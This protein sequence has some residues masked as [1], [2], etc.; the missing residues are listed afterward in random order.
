M[1][2]WNSVINIFGKYT[3]A[4]FTL[5]RISSCFV[6]KVTP[7][8]FEQWYLHRCIAL[9]NLLRFET[10]HTTPVGSGSGVDLVVVASNLPIT[11][12]AIS[13]PTEVYKLGPDH[14]KNLSDTERSTFS[15]G[16]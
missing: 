11:S 7:V 2:F 12:T 10:V 14:F 3:K 6:S 4:M 1:I 15:S 5:N 9:Q 13:A 8:Q 16:A